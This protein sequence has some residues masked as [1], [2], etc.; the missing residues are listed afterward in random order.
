MIAL[1]LAPVVVIS[2][3]MGNI[4]VQLDQKKAPQSVKNFLQY[5]S[6]KHYDGTVFHRVI[7]S[8]MIQGGGFDEKLQQIGA[9]HPPVK[10][11]AGNGLKNLPG[12]IA[13]AR[14][15]V[16]DSATDQ[17][18][19][20]TKENQF[21]DHRD[22]TLRGFGY[23]VFGKVISGMDVVR[24]IEAVRTETRPSGD[25]VPLSDVPAQAVLIKSIRV[26]K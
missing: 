5:V 19:I 20:N 16:V 11:E 18:F 9:R 8:F 14:T 22:D 4:K 26:A 24:K 12:T 7:K 1:L 15:G 10:N 25:G 6:E 23:A 13:M 2:T 21:L 17:F 3:S